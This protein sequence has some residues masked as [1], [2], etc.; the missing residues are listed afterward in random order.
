MLRKRNPNFIFNINASKALHDFFEIFIQK[1]QIIGN[2]MITLLY[3]E[4]K[5]KIKHAPLIRK[6]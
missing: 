1:R 3:I 5:I 4:I 2:A 6:R